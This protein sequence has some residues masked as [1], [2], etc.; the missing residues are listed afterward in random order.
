MQENGHCGEVAIV[1]SIVYRTALVI[2]DRTESEAYINF[3][4]YCMFC[5]QLYGALI[6]SG[7]MEG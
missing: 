4:S 1:G 6:V 3:K 5:E 2:R 7:K